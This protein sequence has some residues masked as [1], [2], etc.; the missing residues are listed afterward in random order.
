[1]KLLV[2]VTLKLHQAMMLIFASMACAQTGA[3]MQ[4]PP[5][6]AVQISDQSAA[7]FRK[8]GA[9]PEFLVAAHFSTATLVA[10]FDEPKDPDH[11]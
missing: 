8:T 10:V 1:M 9:L 7:A 11:Q 5:R 6:L 4:L 3:P 2:L